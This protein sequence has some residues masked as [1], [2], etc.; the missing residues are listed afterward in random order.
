M[1]ASLIR[2]KTTGI[3]AVK[4]V[5]AVTVK[6]VAFVGR[7]ITNEFNTVRLGVEENYVLN[8]WDTLSNTEKFIAAR[9]FAWACPEDDTVVQLSRAIRRAMEFDTLA[10]TPEQ[11]T[12]Q[13]LH[14]YNTAEL[15][16]GIELPKSITA[17]YHSIM[18]ERLT[19]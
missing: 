13:F 19:P 11:K 18:K 6:P 10:H 1:K 12:T 4:A 16:L 7:K 14:L 2:T 9:S 17:H 15:E 5:A 8:N 3:L